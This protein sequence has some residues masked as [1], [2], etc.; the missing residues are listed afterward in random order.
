M[1]IYVKLIDA[2]NNERL[3]DNFV[4]LID[5]PLKIVKERL[6]FHNNENKYYPNFLKLTRSCLVQART[7]SGS[8]ESINDNNDDDIILKNQLLVNYTVKDDKIIY[9]NSILDTLETEINND[10]S[11]NNLYEDYKNNNDHFTNI[12]NKVINFNRLLIQFL[13]GIIW[14]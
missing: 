10:I 12:Y 11:I 13:Y 14:D 4:V 8:K 5:E 7:E 1:K 2:S 9:V 6:F 3:N